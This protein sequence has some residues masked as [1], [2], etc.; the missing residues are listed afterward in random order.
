MDLVSTENML[1]FWLSITGLLFLALAFIFV[2]LIRGRD[3]NSRQME[4]PFDSGYDHELEVALSHGEI[5]EAD[6]RQA[7]AESKIVSKQKFK[8][9]F[10]PASKPKAST[11]QSKWVYITLALVLPII[12]LGIYLH[13]GASSDLPGLFANKKKASEIE[14]FRRQYGS[15]EILIAKLREQLGREP[16]SARGWYLL[17][18]LY[19]SQQE[20][21]KTI[22]AFSKANKYQP[23]DAEIMTQYAQALYFKNDNKLGPYSQGLLNK[24]LNEDP[25]NPLALNLVAVDAFTKD[26]YRTA[27]DYWKRLQE[28]VPT[29]GRDAENVELAIGRAQQALVALQER[30]KEASKNVVD[31]SQPDETITG[32]ADH[33][34]DKS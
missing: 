22:D 26:K 3:K 23:N 17:G 9:I 33:Q 2:P 10:I 27:I 19:F 29:G 20:L 7:K 12:P 28:V 16:S 34:S 1:L 5:S 8:N 32:P 13:M 18:K 21:D 14:E 25:K 15:P 6:Y 11:K 31:M 30:N 4:L 24:V